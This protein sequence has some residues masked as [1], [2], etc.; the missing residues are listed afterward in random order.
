[1]EISL[2]TVT[3]TDNRMVDRKRIFVGR[4]LAGI[5]RSVKISFTEIEV[6]SAVGISMNT[7]LSLPSSFDCR[8]GRFLSIP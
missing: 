1:V 4:G 5:D 6:V 8:W 2:F 3:G 7:L